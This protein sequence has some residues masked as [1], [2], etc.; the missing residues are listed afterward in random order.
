[1]VEYSLLTYTFDGNE[2]ICAKTD[3]VRKVCQSCA[4]FEMCEW[5]S[6]DCLEKFV[7]IVNSEVEIKYV[8]AEKIDE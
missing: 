8:E 7:N 3:D 6:S 5:E 4:L 1:M 2:A